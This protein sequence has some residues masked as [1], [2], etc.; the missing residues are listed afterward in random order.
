MNPLRGFADESD[1]CAENEDASART[2]RRVPR[3]ALSPRRPCPR[4]SECGGN[5]R[6]CEACEPKLKACVLCRSPL[7]F[8]RKFEDPSVAEGII[9]VGDCALTLA[10]A[11]A[12]VAS[13]WRR[14]TGSASG[15]HDLD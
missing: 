13:C 7:V 9:A 6:V 5:W 10:M 1:A 12:V 15:V 11:I 14:R 4:A 3:A 8:A 2:G